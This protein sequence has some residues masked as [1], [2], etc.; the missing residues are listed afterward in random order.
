MPEISHARYRAGQGEPVVLLHGFTATWRCWLPVLPELVARYDVLAPTLT[1]HDG[2]PRRRPD[3]DHS[4]SA[5]ARH[6]EALLDEQGVDTAHLVGNSMGGA[7]ALELAKRGRARS[8][9]ALSPG[10]GWHHGDPEGARVERF[11][12][13]QLRITRA[14]QRRLPSIMARPLARRLAFRDIV[15]HGELLPPAEAVAIAR[16]SLKCEVVEDVFASIR[17]GEGLLR[18]LDQVRVPTLVAWAEHDR[19][20]PLARHQ[21]RFRSEIPGV[22][23]RIMRGV[24][25]VPM[26]DNPGLVAGTIVEWVERHRAPRAESAA[27]L[28]IAAPGGTSS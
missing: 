23:F 21:Q 27:E 10:G 12:R 28:A 8:V 15:R 13:R 1:G 14:A 25:H 4:L 6:V 19:V 7:L 24:G 18:D 5:G 9:V 16:S 2:G 22:T 17:S 20:L 3:H 26:S 11:F